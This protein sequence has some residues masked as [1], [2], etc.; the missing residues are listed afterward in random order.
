MRWTT[1][2]GPLSSARVDVEFEGAEAD[3]AGGLRRA[4]RGAAAE[5]GAEAEDEFVGLEGLGEVIVGAGFEAGDAVLGGAA[6]G[7]QEDRHVGALGAEGAGEGEAGFAGHHDVEH[8]QVGLD[9]A[10][11][12]AGFGGVAGGGDAEALLGEVAGEQ[13]AEADV[14]VDDEDVGVV[15]HGLRGGWRWAAARSSMARASSSMMP[16]MT[17]RKPSTAGAPASR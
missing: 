15:A 5:H 11:L 3:G 7:E 16:R 4:C 13:G 2:S 1:P 12:V 10:Q 9:D 14:V 6:G 17:R 8:E